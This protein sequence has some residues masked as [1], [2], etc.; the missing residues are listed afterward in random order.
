VSVV[1]GSATG[2]LAGLAGSGTFKSIDQTTMSM[3]LEYEFN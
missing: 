3:V 1:P 2:G